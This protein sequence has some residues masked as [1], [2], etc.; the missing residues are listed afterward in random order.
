M[1]FDNTGAPYNFTA[2]LDESLVFSP[3]KY[4]QYSPLFI[5]A[6]YAVAY[7]SCFAALSSVFVHTFL[8][9]RKDIVRRFTSALKSERDVHYR[10]M[11]AYAEVPTWWYGLLG[12]VFLVL[13]CIGVEVFHT[14]LPIWGALVAFVLSAVLSIPLAMLVATANLSFPAQVMHE[15]IAGYMFPGRPIANVLFKT[16]AYIGTSQAIGFSG[17]LKLGSYMKIPPRVMFSVQ[18]VASIVGCFVVVSVQDWM[19]ANIEDICTPDQ[20]NGFT[21]PTTTTFATAT[22][23]WG[24]IGPQRMLGSGALYSPLLWFFLIGALLPIPFYL[25]ARRYPLSFWR[26]INIPIFFSGLGQVPFATGVNYMSWV[27]VGFLFNYV[28]R[29]YRFKWWMR[30]NYVLSAALDA[31]VTIGMM[32][33]FFCLQFPKGGFELDWWGNK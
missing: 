4:S 14:G 20:K 5:S 1:P 22:L 2:I 30:Y 26:Y 25:L 7:G 6:A 3:T 9:F 23:M 13:M 28:I 21:C 32:V 12:G 15:L 19:L 8:W 17:D 31:G 29:K 11:Q 27:L 10:L 24:G 18:V 33:I 16:F